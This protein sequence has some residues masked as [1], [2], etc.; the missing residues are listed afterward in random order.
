MAL[1]LDEAVAVVR[2]ACRP[3]GSGDVPLA[4]CAGRVLAADVASPTDLPR[5]DNSAMDGYAVRAGDTTWAPVR[6]AVVGESRA[7]APAATALG[8]GQAVRVSTGAAMPSGADAVVRVEDTVP[9]EGVVDVGVA[10]EPRRDVRPAGDDVRTGQVVVPAG[11]RLGAGEIGML[12]A[13]GVDRVAVA[14]RPRVALVSTG[15]ELV[16]PCQE[17]AP[18][19]IHDSNSYMLERLVADAGGD[20]VM[21]V[22]G[23]ADT[24]AAVDEAVARA[25]GAADV[26]VVVGGV[27]VG[28]HDHVRAALSDAG[29]DEA[30]WRVALR[31]GHPT[32]FGT[33]DRGRRRTL[34]FGLPGNPGSA[35]VAFHLFV[36][37]ALALLAGDARVPLR[38]A[39]RFRGPGVHKRVG[40]ALALRV[41]LEAGHGAPVAVPAGHNQASHAMTALVG[42]D[43]LAVIPP[44][45]DGVGD[46]DPVSV[47]LLR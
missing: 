8:P 29:V 36:A 40:V 20:V 13:V 2:A 35:F 18:G 6:L 7:G 16:P 10:V 42:V 9:G 39:A 38:V 23:V 44:E 11:T 12:A 26:V 37:P 47:R 31:P 28:R 4:G 30:F 22:R 41:R 45:A 43:G 25:L 33:R 17:P 19:Q 32:W 1:A 46:G 27:S 15:D 14:A 24:R 21:I 34:M 3:L 5:F